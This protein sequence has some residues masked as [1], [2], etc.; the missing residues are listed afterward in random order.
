MVAERLLVDARARAAPSRGTVHEEGVHAVARRGEKTGR[1]G[2]S[3]RHAVHHRR[4]GE[5]AIG[6]R[7]GVRGRSS[8]FPATSRALLLARAR[9]QQAVALAGVPRTVRLRRVARVVAAWRFGV[10][11]ATPR[12][13]T[14]SSSTPPP[15]APRGASDAAEALDMHWNIASFLPESLREHFEVIVSE[16]IFRPWSTNTEESLDDDEGRWVR[17]RPGGGVTTRARGRERGRSRRG[18]ARG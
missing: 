8:R 15:R 3:R 2:D 14:I 10:V 13:R 11:G 17:R 5:D 7:G 1:D 12:A 6:L 16:F 4:D 18:F 9:T